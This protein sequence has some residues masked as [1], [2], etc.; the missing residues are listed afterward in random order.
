MP[1][2][3]EK[4]LTHEAF[5]ASFLVAAD[6][7]DGMA[8]LRAADE[9]P[10]NEGHRPDA[11]R[12]VVKDF[13]AATWVD[14]HGNEPLNRVEEMRA[15]FANEDDA[16]RA[17]DPTARWFM[18]RYEDLADAPPIGSDTRARVNIDHRPTP[19]VLWAYGYVFRVGRVVA[20]LTVARGT[21]APVGSLTRAAADAIAARAL[22]RIEAALESE[23]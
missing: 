5:L 18:T 16:R 21:R 23:R 17:I 3:K 7:P 14:P 22:A 11:L 12:G 1:K 20:A 4:S 15:L 13:A 8:S 6:M 2:A 19:A 9:A 10:L